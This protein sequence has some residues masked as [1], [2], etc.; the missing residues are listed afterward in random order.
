MKAIVVKYHS[1]GY[2]KGSRYS[3]SDSDGNRVIVSSSSAL[4]YDDNKRHAAIALCN[5]MKWTGTL[6]AGEAKI[7]GKYMEVFVWDNGDDR[8]EVK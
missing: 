6:H 4:S 7:G 5:K 8:I 1:P 2:S 3:A